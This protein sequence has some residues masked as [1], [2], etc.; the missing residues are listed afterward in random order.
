MQKIFYIRCT[1]AFLA[2][3]TAVGFSS[4]LSAIYTKSCAQTFPPIFGLYAIF[5]RNFTKIVA[6]PSNKNKNYLVHLKGRS[7]LKK[8]YKQYQNRPIKRDTTPVQSMWPSN[9]QHTGLRSWQKKTNIQTPYF[10]TYSGCALFDLPKFCM[11]VELVVPILKGVNLFSI[12]FIVFPLEDKMLIFGHAVN[13][14]TGW[15][16]F[17]A[18]CR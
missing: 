3:T 2:Y 18:S 7:M 13:L 8:R 11:V 4:N 16:H 15:R 12:Q 10:R 17:A 1:S 9:E 5:D 6:P 14:D